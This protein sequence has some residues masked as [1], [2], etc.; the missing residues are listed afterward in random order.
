[1]TLY[2]VSLIPVTCFYPRIP[3]NRASG[4]DSK[5]KR[6]CCSNSIKNCINAMPGGAST[7]DCLFRISAKPVIFVYKMEVP[8]HAEYMLDPKQVFPYVPDAISNS[9]YWLTQAP[10]D[11]RELVY[12]V[13]ELKVKSGHDPD[14]MPVYHVGQICLDL[15][16]DKATFK[17]NIQQ[18]LEQAN[19]NN[20]EA[21]AIL[22]EKYGLST[23]LRNIY[24]RWMLEETLQKFRELKKLKED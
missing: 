1:M 9:E 22:I 21:L 3:G 8:D 15:I 19:P 18:I 14:G 13:C 17:D 4:E 6:I 16:H 7:I 10:D 11:I 5:I 12:H 23:C 20:K 24:S 2:H